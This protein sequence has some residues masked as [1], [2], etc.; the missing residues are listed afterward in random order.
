MKIVINSCWGGFSISDQC[1]ALM[2][3]IVDESCTH[4]PWAYHDWPDGKSD[5]DFRTD[6]R[7]I[8]LIEEKGSEWCSGE[9][10]ALTI[11][12]IPDD[13]NWEIEEY[14]GSEWVSEVHRTWR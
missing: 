10:A 7:L 14:D 3:A 12:E 6:E 1:A 2:G 5:R 13:V 8:A 11:V 9:C 4:Y